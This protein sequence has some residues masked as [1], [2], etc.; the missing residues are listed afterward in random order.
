MTTD[1]RPRVS[2]LARLNQ[3]VRQAI[4]L[5]RYDVAVEA[6]DRALAT[7]TNASPRFENSQIAIRTWTDRGTVLEVDDRLPDAL[8]ARMKALELARTLDRFPASELATILVQIAQNLRLLDRSNEATSYLA[9]ARQSIEDVPI[10]AS[11][12]RGMVRAR[13]LLLAGEADILSDNHEMDQAEFLKAKALADWRRI[14]DTRLYPDG[15][16]DLANAIT[17]YGWIAGEKNDDVA[18][19]ERYAEALAANERLY[20]GPDY[21]DGHPDLANAYNNMGYA[22]VILAPCRNS[23]DALPQHRAE[24][25]AVRNRHP[26]N[27]R[28]TVA[29]NCSPATAETARPS[30]PRQ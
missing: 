18:M 10:E 3:A 12:Q 20:L 21:P 15:H 13:C 27:A 22:H 2:Q 29:E 26:A 9:E 1:H 11:K 4:K 30:R 19:A 8:R 6:S 23:G 17:D 25:E 28:S 14:Y 16:P 24:L 7:L 5:G